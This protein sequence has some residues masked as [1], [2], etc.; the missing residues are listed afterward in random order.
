MRRNRVFLPQDALDRWLE[1]GRVE[2][3]GEIMTMKPELQRFRLK[4]A[5]RFVDEVGGAGDAA[6]LLGKVKDLEQ[7]TEFGGE[8]YADSVLL[9]DAAYQVVE[10]FVGEPEGG[11]AAAAAAQGA[12]T[13]G[14][15]TDA[16]ADDGDVDL[17]AK[18]FLS[19]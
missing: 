13:R 11:L 19:S 3:D 17:L 14:E 9:G 7:I 12:G 4:S 2:V 1:E 8:H 10:G 18:L 16:A 6:K 15:A 5:V